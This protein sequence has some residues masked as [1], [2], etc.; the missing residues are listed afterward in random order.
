MNLYEEVIIVDPNLDD[1][2]AEEALNKV[3]DLITKN[4]GEILRIDR[5]GR[6][7]LAYVLNKRDRGNY[8][9]IL[10]KAPSSTIPEV[11]KLC[12]VIDAIFKFMIVKFEKKRHI[13]AVMASLKKGDETSSE[14]SEQPEA[15][16]KEGVQ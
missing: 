8:F 12:R 10:F 13:E 11:E 4:G 16:V 9:I 6:R 14:S 3:T 5:W 15:E 1:S 2:A 7:K